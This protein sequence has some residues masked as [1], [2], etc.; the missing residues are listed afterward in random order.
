MFVFIIFTGFTGELVRS[1]YAA[2]PEVISPE[3]VNYLDRKL[4][5][6][7]F[8]RGKDVQHTVPLS[9]HHVALQV[10]GT[11]AYYTNGQ[12]VPAL[13]LA[14]SQFQAAPPVPLPGL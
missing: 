2:M 11:L 3:L 1:P 13:G 8:H 9:I 14:S 4:T 12:T 5:W 7:I 6:G 10:S